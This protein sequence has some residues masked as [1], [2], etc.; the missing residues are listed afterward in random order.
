[1][2]LIYQYILKFSISIAIVYIFYHF[3]LRRLTFYNSNRWY[4]LL[5][6]AS[7]FLIPVINISSLFENNQLSKTQ[8]LQYIAALPS[9]DKVKQEVVTHPAS[10]PFLKFAGE[11]ILL[12]L[13]LG[14]MV[15]LVR[16]AVQY[17]SFLKVKRNSTL[18]FKHKV[19]IF[20]VNK[21]IIPFSIGNS[22]FIN[23]HMHNEEELKEIIRHEF[24]HVKQKHSVDTFVGE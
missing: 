2:F 21:P 16:L 22:I 14:A 7:S 18:L 11:L 24:I 3:L 23:Q 1:M 5:Y 12:I 6:T 10:Y 13:A 20:Q 15:M 9:T 8:I 17:F 19:A 4:L